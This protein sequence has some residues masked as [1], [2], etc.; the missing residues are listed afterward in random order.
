MAGLSQ[1]RGGLDV[2]I[3]FYIGLLAGCLILTRWMVKAKTI[4]GAL[5]W[6]K[7]RSY[8]A[9]LVA[10]V[11]LGNLMYVGLALWDGYLTAASAISGYLLASVLF[12]TVI[13]AGGVTLNWLFGLLAS[14]KNRK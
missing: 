8:I 3:L 1:F 10:F 11:W 4:R 13:L 12:S 9:F 2:G 14:T 6:F 7:G 5:T